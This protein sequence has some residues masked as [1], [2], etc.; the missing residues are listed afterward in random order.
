MLKK[1]LAVASAATAL[2]GYCVASDGTT[3]Y[4]I[5]ERP[6]EVEK[7]DSL[8][9]NVCYN[10]LL[11]TCGPGNV[12]GIATGYGLDGLAIESRWG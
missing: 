10:V 1:N 3:V 9:G 6:I 2:K 8:L 7:T 12:V 4:R 11:F 5:E